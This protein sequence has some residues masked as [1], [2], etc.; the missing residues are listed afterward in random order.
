MK[1]NKC[2][3]TDLMCHN[4]KKCVVIDFDDDGNNDDC[5]ND[6]DNGKSFCNVFLLSV[7]ITLRG[8]CIEKAHNSTC[9]TCTCI[10]C[11]P[12]GGRIFSSL[13]TVHKYFIPHTVHCFLIRCTN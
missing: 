1:G 12:A 11:Y 5:D 4:G 10:A 8:C 13:R 9:I 6:D 7:R 2:L 3:G